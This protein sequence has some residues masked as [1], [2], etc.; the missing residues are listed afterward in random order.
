M[1]LMVVLVNVFNDHVKSSS[2]KAVPSWAIYTV[3]QSNVLI[4][5]SRFIFMAQI[6]TE[7]ETGNSLLVMRR[8]VDAAAKWADCWSRVGRL[9]PQSPL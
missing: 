6:M 7:H 8:C 1:L 2:S 4:S 3:K 5:T 9:R